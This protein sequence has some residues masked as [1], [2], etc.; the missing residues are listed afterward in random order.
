MRGHA[1]INEPIAI[2]GPRC[3][4][5]SGFTKWGGSVENE[6][7]YYARTA[8]IVLL[9][10]VLGLTANIPH[11]VKEHRENGFDRSV[12]KA[13]EQKGIRKGVVFTESD[14]RTVFPAN[15]PDLESGVIYVRDLEPYDPGFHS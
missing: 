10:S 1:K 12:L 13:V 8:G 11:L 15:P 2:L 9:C 7:A 5:G 4:C 6:Q 14:Y 3:P